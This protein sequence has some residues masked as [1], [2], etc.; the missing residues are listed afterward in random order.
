AARA[1]RHEKTATARRREYRFGDEGREQAGDAGVEGVASVLQNFRSR[2][3]RQ[4]M[5]GRN[6]AVLEF[7][8]IVIAGLDPAIHSNRLSYAQAYG[9]DARIKSGHDDEIEGQNPLTQPLLERRELVLQC[10]RHLGAERGEV[11]LDHR[12]LRLP[13]FLVDGRH[14]LHVGGIDLHALDVDSAFGWNLADRRVHRFGLAVAALEDPFQHA[15]VLCVAWPHELAVAG[16][17]ET[18]NGEDLRPF[19]AAL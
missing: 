18:V 17:A 12:D 19:V 6:D 9:M 7:H 14:Y 16:L 3:C 2:G 10:L 1:P 8:V 5:S 15:G 11:F 13:A 4:L